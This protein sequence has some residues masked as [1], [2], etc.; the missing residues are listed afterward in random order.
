MKCLN[1]NNDVEE[2]FCQICGQKVSTH[3]FSLKYLFDKGILNGVFMINKGLF[4]TLKELLTRPGHSIREYINGKRV[5]HLNAFNLLLLLITVAYF[6]DTYTN[7]KLAD[8][9]NESS[10]EFATSFE[11]FMKEYP[12]LIYIMNVPLM[13][14]SSFLIFRKSKLNL[15]ENI[16]LSTYKSS[17][18]I[19]LTMP[20]ILLAIFYKDLSVLK[21]AYQLSPLLAFG[22][23]FWFYYQFFSTYGYK[24]RSLIFRSFFS[25]LIFVLT[26]G[27]LIAAIVALRS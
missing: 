10:K 17:A 2:N 12:R 13:A 20:L 4:Y 19:L 11:K 25:I 22:Y 14:I 8:V 7:L 9:M 18:E 16:I 3:R 26:Q 21:I 15:A 23:S 27:T 1:C 24:K 6:L 5:K